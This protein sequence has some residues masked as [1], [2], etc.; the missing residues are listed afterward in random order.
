MGDAKM[1]ASKNVLIVEDD[2]V[3][4]RILTTAFLQAGYHPVIARSPAEAARK[5]GLERIDAV[6]SDVQLEGGSAFDLLS[7]LRRSGLGTPV[8]LATAYATPDLHARAKAAGSARLIEKPCPTSD[9][10]D[11]VGQAM[12]EWVT[13]R[14]AGQILLVEDHAPSRAVAAQLLGEAGFSTLLAESGRRALELMEASTLPLDLVVMDLTTPGPSGAELVRRI[15]ALDPA[16]EIVMLAGDACR[17]DIVA[18]YAE[19]AASLLRKPYGEDQ[20]LQFVRTQMAISRKRRAAAEREAKERSAR[21]ATSRVRRIAR[22]TFALA[23]R[24][25][26][27]TAGLMGAVLAIGL[28]LM[29]AVSPA[30]VPREATPS[31]EQQML[32]EMRRFGDDYQKELRWYGITR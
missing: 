18:A 4:L 15:R 5:A 29:E 26:V 30:L 8:I 19:G 3:Q 12:K 10:V 20:F 2:P 17:E 16:V 25:W 31:V 27:P 32:R 7:E 11:S 28:F 24:P 1:E 14:Q 9:I 6:L 23:K 21:P 22:S 13:G